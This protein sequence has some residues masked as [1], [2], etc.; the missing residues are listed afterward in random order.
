MHLK[1][2]S[3]IREHN[4]EWHLSPAYDLVPVKTVLPTD[5]DDLALTLNGK[6]RK[7]REKDF[8]TAA[9][10]MRLTEVQYTRTL[11]RVLRP[12]SANLDAALGRSF[13]SDEFRSRVRAS[14]HER[15]A[16]FS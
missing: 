4:G 15:L 10:T 8:R 11:R 3:L 6:N 12:L 13:L 9:T 2:F 14:I 5:E 1:N 16:L 7:L